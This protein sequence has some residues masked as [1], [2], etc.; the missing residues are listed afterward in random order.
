MRASRLNSA[1]EDIVG[2]GVVGLFIA[3]D[4]FVR[5]V[6]KTDGWIFFFLVF[7]PL[8][9]LTWRWEFLQVFNQRVNPQAIL[10]M[11]AVVLNLIVAAHVGKK[12]RHFRLVLLFVGL[13][14]LSVALTPTSWSINEWLRLLSGV[15]FFFSAGLV[16]QE[17]NK[18]DR[19]SL[20]LLIAVCVP[21]VLSIFQLLE[22]LPYEYWDWINQQPIGRVSGTYQHPLDIVFFLVYAVPVALY[23]WEEASNRITEK[24]FLS[25]FLLL[26]FLNLIFTYHRSGW[27]AILAEL[28]IWYA[29]KNQLKRVLIG[30]LVLLLIGVAFSSW[31]LTFYEPG[32]EILSGQADLASGQFLRGRGANWIGY[33]ISYS[34]GGPVRWVFGKGG[35]IADLSLPG[36]S[37][38]LAEDEPHN[39]FIRILHAYGIVGLA[40]YLSLLFVFLREGLLLRKCGQ[41]YQAR[42]GGILICSIVAI[43][44]LSL[45]TEP[46]RYPTGVWYLFVLGSIVSCFPANPVP[47]PTRIPLHAAQ[48]AFC[49]TI[50]Y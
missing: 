34:E 45:T 27:I 32:T 44:L 1:G 49:D 7:K 20:S 28:G 3:A 35:S 8:I 25:I 42:M 13:A 37:A 5:W 24:I 30:S 11:C 23:R 18:F 15:S 4:A 2:A 43:C 16:L 22:L 10:S 46:M 39:D 40:L 38:V 41:P 17:K 47:R 33:L 12:P 29:L 19:F 36:I 48:H 9:D 31:V 14:T 26:V 21:L 50:E 6:V